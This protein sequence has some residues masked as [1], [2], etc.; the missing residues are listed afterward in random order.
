MSFKN[1]FQPIINNPEKH[2]SVLYYDENVIIIKDMF[3]KSVRHLL[4]IPRHQQVTKK[5]PLD[6]FN[7]FYND[8]TGEELY[9]MIEK[10][11][12]QAKDLIIDNLKEKLDMKDEIILQDFKTNFIKAGVHS[13]PS[14]DNFHIHVIT[15]DFNSPRMKNKKH[16]NSFT[17]KFFVPFD[18][19]NPLYNEKYYQ[20]TNKD[21]ESYDSQSDVSSSSSETEKPD[22]I[23]LIRSKP[24][25][26]NLIKSTS[27]KCTSCN[28]TFGNSV[29]KLKD[30]LNEEFEKKFSTL[31]DTK[32]IKINDI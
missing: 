32:L 6:V 20:L 28:K 21:N 12:E 10:Y 7:A 8:F 5:H 18:Q 30:H 15:Q 9:E 24:V 3:P 19:L 23:R 16:Y 2:D 17:T 26:E 4:V 13:I 1:A 29:I 14:L 25:L 27:F 11:V 22:F 31:G